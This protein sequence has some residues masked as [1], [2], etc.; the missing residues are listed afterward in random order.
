MESIQVDSEIELLL[1]LE[2]NIDLRGCKNYLIELAHDRGYTTAVCELLK[3]E[4]NYRMPRARTEL[5]QVDK[6]LVCDSK[7]DAEIDERASMIGYLLF[8]SLSCLFLER[9]IAYLF[10]SCTIAS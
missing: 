5:Q 2:S 1:L 10:K 9:F 7:Q 6:L 8:I 3:D 4:K